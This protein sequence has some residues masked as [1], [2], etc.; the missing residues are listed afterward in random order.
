MSRMPAQKSIIGKK[1]G[2]TQIFVPA[3]GNVVPVTVI[4]AGPCLVMQV[5]TPENDGYSAV[6]LGFADY[7][8]KKE[9]KIIKPM[10]GHFKKAGMPP[11][12]HLKEFKL[13]DAENLKVGDKIEADAFK[14]GEKVDVTG[15]TKGR[16]F[17]GAVKRWGLHTQKETHGV[18]PVH[19]HAGSMG[20]NSDP[21]RIMK[22][23]KMAGQYG[24]ERVTTQNLEVIKIDKE[25]NLIAVKGAVPGPK[26]SIVFVRDAVK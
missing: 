14:E 17:S 16:G 19:R 8:E 12:R 22:N 6:Q 3:N 1:L 26:G 9:K 7:T 13:K 15:M 23:K 24:H 21:S 20:A 18:G 11:K 2:M 5:K 25:K 4:E 10:K